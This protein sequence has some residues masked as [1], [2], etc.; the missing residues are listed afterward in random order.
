MTPT[1][2]SLAFQQNA[3]EGDF[4]SL[5]TV[6]F[7]PS[8]H[9]PPHTLRHADVLNGWFLICL[10][11]SYNWGPVY[12]IL[13]TATKLILYTTCLV[14]NTV[15]LW[16]KIWNMKFFC[17]GRLGSKEKIVDLSFSEQ[18]LRVDFSIFC[19]QKK[20]NFCFKNIVASAL[21]NYIK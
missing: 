4:W 2:L 6:T 13:Q 15:G 1:P 19:G 8:A 3:Y 20:I 16:A 9:A 10:L 12:F 17:L 21:K 14:L 5:C 7:V 18:L 11:Y